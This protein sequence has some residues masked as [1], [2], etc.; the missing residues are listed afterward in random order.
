[1]D[2][3]T[4]DMLESLK[5]IISDFKNEVRSDIGE[6]KTMYECNEKKCSER[7]EHIYTEL[8]KQK[9]YAI[10]LLGAIL[11]AVIGVKIL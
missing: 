2:E 1:M 8:N 10:S 9:W 6:I 7:R 11:L 3:H 4:K 5:D